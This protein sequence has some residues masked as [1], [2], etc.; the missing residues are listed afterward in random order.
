[1]PHAHAIMGRAF[2][3]LNSDLSWSTLSLQDR[4]ER[5]KAAWRAD[6][7]PGRPENHW[8][9]YEEWDE[10][11]WARAIERL[12]TAEILASGAQSD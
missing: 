3:R 8:K 11:D 2:R 12:T 7:L 5:L 4:A 6:F 10:S 9:W 1:M